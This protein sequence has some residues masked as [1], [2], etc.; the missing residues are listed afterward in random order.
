MP[1]RQ[2]SIIDSPLGPLTVISADGVLAGVYLTV[3]DNCSSG[4]GQ[5]VND[6]HPQATTELIEYFSGSREKFSVDILLEGTSFQRQVWNALQEVPFGETCSYGELAEA[7]GNPKAS[8]AVGSANGRNPISIIV[9]CHRVIAAD[10]SLGGYASGLDNK[11]WLL[12]HEKSWPR[13]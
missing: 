13:Q 1:D 7:V 12:A 8:R 2:H 5:R 3:R 6:A 11:K 9:P 4:L 10:G